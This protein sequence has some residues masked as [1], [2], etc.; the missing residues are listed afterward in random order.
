MILTCAEMKALEQM[1]FARGV[2]AEALM[3]KA[4]EQ[5][6]TEIRQTFPYAGVCVVVFGKGNNGGDALVAARALAAHGWTVYLLP[7]FP[8]S[9]WADLP[10]RKR[11]EASGCLTAGPE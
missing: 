2:S 3:E 6:A 4:G 10:K 9:S 1:A 5:I 7:A 8:E 11:T